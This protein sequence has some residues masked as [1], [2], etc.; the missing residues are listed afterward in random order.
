MV[1]ARLI[2]GDV[3]VLPDA[4]PVAVAQRCDERGERKR[5]DTKSV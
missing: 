1:H 4:N 2:L 5:G 3:D